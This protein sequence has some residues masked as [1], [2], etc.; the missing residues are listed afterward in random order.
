[1]KVTIQ[2]ELDVPQ[3]DESWT[4]DE[5]YQLVC[6]EYIYYVQQK[7]LEDSIAF[8]GFKDSPNAGDET[9]RLYG[10]Q[11]DKHDTW[12]KIAKNVKINTLV[13]WTKFG[14]GAVLPNKKI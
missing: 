2:L 5:V 8:Y 3:I 10:L 7:H 6:D 1:M 14:P 4:E 9:K 12:A 11:M 13:C